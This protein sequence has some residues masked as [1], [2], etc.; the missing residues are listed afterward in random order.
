MICTFSHINPAPLLNT[1]K[2]VGGKD[3]LAVADMIINP[4]TGIYDSEYTSQFA[5]ADRLDT[6]KVS[7]FLP[8]F[9]KFFLNVFFS[10]F[11]FDFCAFYHLQDPNPGDACSGARRCEW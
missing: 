2:Q 7:K 3:G 5:N 10:I 4:K 9:L 11:V 6:S 1:L 8:H